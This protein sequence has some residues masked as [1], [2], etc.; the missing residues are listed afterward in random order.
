MTYNGILKLLEKCQKVR[1]CPGWKLSGGGGG[2]GG[3]CLGWEG[4]CLGWELT[5]GKLSRATG[6]NC[7]GSDWDNLSFLLVTYSLHVSNINYKF[8]NVLLLKCF[9]CEIASNG[10]SP[11]TMNRHCKHLKKL[12]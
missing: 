10:S 8:S 12:N 7:W 11:F 1:N 9:T 6:D 4:I 2:G 3:Y 5:I